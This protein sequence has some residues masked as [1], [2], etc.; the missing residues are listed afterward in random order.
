MVFRVRREKP[1][2]FAGAIAR[3]SVAGLM[4]ISTLAACTPT[5]DG[6]ERE[7]IALYEQS[8]A[9]IG[10]T[11]GTERDYHTVGFEAGLTREQAIAITAYE[12]T[13]DRAQRLEDGKVRL[14][15]GPCAPGAEDGP[16]MLPIGETET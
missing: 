15:E 8:V 10:C 4:A 16:Q 6:V 5:P 2:G 9:G 13:A 3:H 11:I 1:E 7:Q 12:L 14:I